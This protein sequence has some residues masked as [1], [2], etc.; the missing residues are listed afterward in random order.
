MADSDLAGP[1]GR[2]A[3]ACTHARC[4]AIIFFKIL[5]SYF[6]KNIATG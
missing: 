5:H 2:A 6:L 4:A 1:S 3:P